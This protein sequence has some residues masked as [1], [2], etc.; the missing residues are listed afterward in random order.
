VD[1]DVR[2][3]CEVLNNLSGAVAADYARK[4]LDPARP[5]GL[6]RTLHRCADT[7]VVWT[8]E[9]SATGYADEAL[10]LRRNVR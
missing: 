8:E 1:A 5:D 4:H 2:C 3:R 10:V 7:G 6:G 9:R